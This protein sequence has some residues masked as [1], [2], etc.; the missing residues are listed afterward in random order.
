MPEE[1][2]YLTGRTYLFRLNKGEDLL[3]QLQEFCHNNQ[4]KCA[5]LNAIGAVSGATYSFFDQKKKKYIKVHK[6]EDLE[7]LNLTGNV[8][9]MDDKPMVHAHITL[10]GENGV[11]IGG[12]M[13]QGCTVYACE[14]FLQELVGEPK[15]RKSDK[16]A[17]L[18]LWINPPL[19]PR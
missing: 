19:K 18:L 4:V 2:P 9:L 17:G 3:E 13:M 10:S 12:H 5:T 16:A 11:A 15:I 6:E 7:I 1:R 14:V 8:S